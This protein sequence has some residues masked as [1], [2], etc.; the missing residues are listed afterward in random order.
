MHVAQLCSGIHTPVVLCHA[1]ARRRRSGELQQGY[2]ADDYEWDFASIGKKRK[3]RTAG[4]AGLVK[5]VVVVV[6][7][8]GACGSSHTLH[9]CGWDFASIGKKRKR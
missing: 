6:G 8:G 9:A 7:G 1:A 2:A 5:V 3:R 4:K